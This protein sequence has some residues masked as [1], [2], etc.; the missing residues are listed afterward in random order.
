MVPNNPSA[1]ARILKHIPGVSG[2]S[3]K[4]LLESIWLV[5]LLDAESGNVGSLS[6]ENQLD[7][8][9]DIAVSVFV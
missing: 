3:L 2:N 5:L 8:A 6:D 4:S 7:P 1:L 9:G